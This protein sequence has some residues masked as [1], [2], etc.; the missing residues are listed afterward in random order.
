MGE[1]WVTLC[2]VDDEILTCQSCLENMQEENVHLYVNV[3]DEI[4]EVMCDTCW[5]KD[6]RETNK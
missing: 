1:K 4:E 2:L 5:S 6:Q 3:N